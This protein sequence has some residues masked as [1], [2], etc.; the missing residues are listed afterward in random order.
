MKDT[1]EESAVLKQ[2]FKHEALS[3]ELE[4]EASEHPQEAEEAVWEVEQGYDTCSPGSYVAQ[5][6]KEDHGSR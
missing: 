5:E 4:N 6:L 2:R 1:P 3:R